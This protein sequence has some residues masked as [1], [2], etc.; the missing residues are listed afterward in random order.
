[1]VEPGLQDL[2]H[3]MAN[4]EQGRAAIDNPEARI[5]AVRTQAY[6]EFAAQYNNHQVDPT[7]KVDVAL[8]LGL[9]I[10]VTMPPA[11]QPW[12]WVAE[13]M[14][15]LR[16]KVNTALVNFNSSGKNA[17]GLD[18]V[19]RDLEFYADFCH[20]DPVLFYVYMA[21]DHG[22]NV[23]AWNSS[24]LP[25]DMAL[26]LGAGL[27]Q[28]RPVIRDII[29]PTS[30]S[31]RKRSGSDADDVLSEFVKSSQQMLQTA[32][33]APV[34]TGIALDAP[35]ALASQASTSSIPEVQCAVR[36]EA[37]GK[38]ANVLHEQLQK[39]PHATDVFDAVKAQLQ[40]QLCALLT[41][42]AQ[43]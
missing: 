28:H 26:D 17:A 16:T 36:A 42:L 18:D 15:Y 25:D 9:Q 11:Q 20:G 21:W 38:H 1:M 34:Q 8:W 3:R 35:T 2:L 22:R 33:A 43:V 5:T 10:D 23:P 39:L 13:T 6:Q 32:M 4:P 37:I 31:K 14:A 27:R 7:F 30:G 12:T 41:Q 24:L 29:A 40:M 19:A